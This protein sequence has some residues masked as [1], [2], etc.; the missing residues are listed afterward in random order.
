VGVTPA[1]QALA[2][3]SPDADPHRQDEPYRRALAWMYARLAATL[4]AFTGGEAARDLTH[5]LRG[6]GLSADRRFGGGSMK[7][8]ASLKAARQLTERGRSVIIYPEGS[9]TRDPDTWPMRGKSGAVR[10]ALERGIPIVPI[11]HWGTQAVMGRYSKKI[12]F[13]PRHT[14]DIKVGD[15]LDLSAYAGKP[16]TNSVLTAATNDLMNAITALLEDLRGE[17]APATR[18]DPS[19]HNQA[20]TGKF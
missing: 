19:A 13:W 16:L 6:A 2:E 10:L 14:V 7:S 4:N 17:K 1:L 9:L 12:S 5:E 15:P 11:A 18:W 20:E 8:Q 3:Q